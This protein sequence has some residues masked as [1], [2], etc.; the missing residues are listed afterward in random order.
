MD[1]WRKG[2][3]PL[4]WHCTGTL[5]R[6]GAAYWLTIYPRARRELRVWERHAR[7]IPDRTLREQALHKLTVER[8]NPEA[9]ALFAILAPRRARAH[10]IRLI[11]AYQLLYDYLDAVNELSGCTDL[12]NG[13]QLHRSLLDAVRPAPSTCDYYQFNRIHNDG[14]YVHRLIDTCR[15]QVSALKSSAPLDPVLS[16]A[17][18]RVGDAQS[19]NHAIASEGESGII[20]WC[21]DQ[22]SGDAYLWWEIAAGGISCLGVHALFA[23]AAHR[24]AT[25]HDALPIDAAYFPSICALSALL[26]SLSDHTTDAGTANHS[27]TAHY[28]DSTHAA[29]RFLT[30]AEEAAELTSELRDHRRH[31]VILAG[32]LVFYLSSSA[33]RDGFAAPVAERMIENL[34][35]IV[36]STRLLMRVRRRLHDRPD[37]PVAE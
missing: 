29:E 11:V 9:A 16:R 37:S 30:I 22:I 4:G 36:R 10:L 25:I 12:E 33:V 15:T 2:R 28:R 32:I 14:G 19:Y 24:D 26:D 27:F 8:L 5:V 1:T 17:V 13:L 18:I 7:T 3:N 35:P 23:L 20:A 34:S 21:R 6:A 31:A